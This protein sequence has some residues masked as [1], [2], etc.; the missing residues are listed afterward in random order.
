[1]ITFREFLKLE[2]AVI[3]DRDYKYKDGKV[4]ITK[5]KFKEVHR[6][7]KSSDG[8]FM[9]VLTDKGTSL[10]PV[11]FVTDKEFH[12]LLKENDLDLNEGKYKLVDFEIM[13]KTYTKNN[14]H[15]YA[16][17]LMAK[18]TED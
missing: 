4:Y 14:N 15:A 16:R 13:M 12:E 10:V 3:R 7:Y 6:D 1:M 17:T 18:L 9:M 5:D 2:E 8:K 11:E